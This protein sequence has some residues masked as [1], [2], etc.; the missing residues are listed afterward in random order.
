MK[1][2]PNES[3]SVFEQFFFVNIINNFQSWTIETQPR[4]PWLLSLGR[5]ILMELTHNWEHD[6]FYKHKKKFD[7]HGEKVPKFMTK[8]SYLNKSKPTLKTCSW[9]ITHLIKIDDC[10]IR[11]LL[12]LCTWTQQ[13]ICYMMLTAK[14]N[15]HSFTVFDI[16]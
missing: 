12:W 15:S 4:K 14:L 13:P 5:C 16:Y 7:L 1:T 6:F 10:N 11:E 8:R 2:I 3:G 9:K